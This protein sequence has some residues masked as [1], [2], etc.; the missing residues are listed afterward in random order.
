MPASPT[1]TPEHIKDVNTRY[2]DAA[3][4]EFDA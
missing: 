1:A 4:H 3:A 2:H